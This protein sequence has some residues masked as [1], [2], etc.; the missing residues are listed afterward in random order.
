M[1]RSCCKKGWEVTL[2]STLLGSQRAENERRTLR[3]DAYLVVFLT[4]SVF[5][6]DTMIFSTQ[7]L[8]GLA[9]WSGLKSSM[10]SDAA[11]A[12]LVD[13]YSRSV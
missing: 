10:V 5:P 2:G 9:A 4:K 6:R 11:V 8:E 12:S 13:P 7:N 3:V 1:T